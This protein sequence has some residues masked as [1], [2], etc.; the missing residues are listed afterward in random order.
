MI[1]LKL[2]N[3]Y[4]SNSGLKKTYIANELKLSLYGL[5]KKLSGNTEF[6]A[7]EIYDISKILNLSLEEVNLIFFANYSEFNSHKK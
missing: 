6:K 1:D 2:L 7:S 5:R 3:K 4:I